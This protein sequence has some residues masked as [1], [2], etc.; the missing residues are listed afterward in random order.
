MIRPSSRYAR[1]DCA[2]INVNSARDYRIAPWRVHFYYVDVI[3]KRSTGPVPVRW[4]GPKLKPCVAPSSFAALNKLG[5]PSRWSSGSLSLRCSLRLYRA[6]HRAELCRT[7]F[8]ARRQLKAS[9]CNGRRSS[10]H[11]VCISLALPTVSLSLSLSLSPSQR[12]LLTV[13][14]E[15]ERVLLH[16]SHYSVSLSRS[17]APPCL[18]PLAVVIVVIA[19]VIVVAL[20]FAAALCKNGGG[21]AAGRAS[22][23]R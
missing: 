14:N 17:S 5:G 9:L 23:Y 2:A 21:G 18:P 10:G 12:G 13:S 15:S 20:Q 1:R 4:P 16:D 8:R 3:N 7:C 6:R 19:I 11:W 22:E